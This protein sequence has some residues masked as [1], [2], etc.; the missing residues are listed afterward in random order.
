MLNQTVVGESP[1]QS[2]MR[3]VK[4]ISDVQQD[5]ASRHLDVRDL[6]LVE[7]AVKRVILDYIDQT[8]RMPTT[9]IVRAQ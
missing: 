6:D 9:L 8:G 1:I 2:I 7:R 3:I 4:S 5:G